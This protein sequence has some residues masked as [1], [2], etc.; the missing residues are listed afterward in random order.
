MSL[1]GGSAS[2]CD[3][4][5]A[6]TSRFM[7]AMLTVRDAPAAAEFYARAL[8]AVETERHRAPNGQYV[9]GMRLDGLSFFVVDE[10]TAAFNVSPTTLGGTTVRIRLD[11]ADPDAVAARA[12][13]AGGREIFPVADQPYGMRQG[14]VEDPYGHHWLIGKPLG[15]EP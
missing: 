13:A 1:L 6:M 4:G 7:A 2:V 15:E 3:H 5:G 11:V 8:G 14:R 9:I 12:V 10:N